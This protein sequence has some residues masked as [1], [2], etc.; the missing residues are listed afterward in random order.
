MLS[1]LPQL[2]MQSIFNVL[3][4]SASSNLSDIPLNCVCKAQ[5]RMTSQVCH[6]HFLFLKLETLEHCTLPLT[7][8]WHR[9]YR[10]PR[11]GPF[12]HFVPHFRQF[13]GCICWL[14]FTGPVLWEAVSSGSFPRSLLSYGRSS[15]SWCANGRACFY[16]FIL[17]A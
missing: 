1:L 13:S 5:A 10:I 11:L 4:L 16:P 2:F 9:K 8:T 6:I 7:R 3:T 17:S 15:S 14:F 12:L